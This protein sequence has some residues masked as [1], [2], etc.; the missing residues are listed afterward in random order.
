MLQWCNIT[1]VLYG[2]IVF[3]IKLSILLQ[4][5]RIFV[6]NRKS[7]RALF[8]SIQILIWTSFSFYLVDTVFEIAM[9]IPRERIWN[10]LMTDGHCFNGNA[11]CIATGIFNVISDFSILVLEPA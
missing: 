9:C 10:I 3:L 8:I 5:L 7:S 6:L 11:A 4:Y 2:I 1:S